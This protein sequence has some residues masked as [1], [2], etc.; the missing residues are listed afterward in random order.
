MGVE[1][2]Q[3]LTGG[4]VAHELQRPEDA[5]PADL[6][7]ARVTLGELAQLWAEDVRA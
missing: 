1:W 3:W 7:D 4:P 5:E 2:H 6:A